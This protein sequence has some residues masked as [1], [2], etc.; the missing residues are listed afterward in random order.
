MLSEPEKNIF[1]QGVATAESG[2]TLMKLNVD[3]TLVL[4]RSDTLFFLLPSPSMIRH[5]HQHSDLS[6]LAECCLT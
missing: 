5:Q 6:R 2:L 3:V 1:K 4:R